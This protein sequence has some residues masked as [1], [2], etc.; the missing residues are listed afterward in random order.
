MEWRGAQ[1]AND[2]ES[3]SAEQMPGQ[4]A[5]IHDTGFL[6]LMPMTYWLT[7]KALV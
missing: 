4:I 5:T 7:G 1:M 6:S 3:C 2:G